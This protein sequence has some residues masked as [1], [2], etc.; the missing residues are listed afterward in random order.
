METMATKRFQ[1]C[2]KGRSLCC[3]L[4]CCCRD[5]SPNPAGYKRSHPPRP[6]AQWKR[7]RGKSTL[8]SLTLGS[9]EAS[10]SVGDCTSPGQRVWTLGSAAAYQQAMSLFFKTKL[11]QIRM[12]PPV[13]SRMQDQPLGGWLRYSRTGGHSEPTGDCQVNTKGGKIVMNRQETKTEKEKKKFQQPRDISH[14]KKRISNRKGE[15]GLTLL[16][17][18]LPQG[19]AAALGTRL[20]PHPPSSRQL[21][22]N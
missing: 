8:L 17:S 2:F 15:K 6:V 10:Q 19:E 12:L 1:S 4:P 14:S 18:G 7:E 9:E 3:H 5:S 13:V 22:T 21:E 11:S 20:L 16:Q